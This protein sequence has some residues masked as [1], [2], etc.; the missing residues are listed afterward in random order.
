MKI[1]GAFPVRWAAQDGNDGKSV[2][3]VKTEI[4]YAASTSGTTKPSS[5][6][7]TTIPFVSEGNYLWT[8]THVEYS[9]GTMTDSYST[10]RQGIDGCMMR[11]TEWAKGVEYHNDTSLTTGNRFLDIVCVGVGTSSMERYMCR[12]THTSTDENKPNGSTST[13]WH[14]LDKN[15]PIY[16]PLIMADNAMLRFTQTNQLLL[17]NNSGMVTGGMSGGSSLQIWAGSEGVNED[18]L[19][20]NPKFGVYSDGKSFSEGSMTTYGKNITVDGKNYRLKV[21]EYNGNNDGQMAYYYPIVKMIVCAYIKYPTS[22]T[23]PTLTDDDINTVTVASPLPKTSPNGQTWTDEPIASVGYY[24]AGYKYTIY[25]DTS[26][27]KS[28]VSPINGIQ[29]SPNHTR[30][31]ITQVKMREE[32]FVYDE[33]G[34]ILGLQTKY[35]DKAGNLSWMLDETG[36]FKASLDH[37]WSPNNRRYYFAD[38]SS[39]GIANALSYLNSNAKDPAKFAFPDD[40]AAVFSIFCSANSTDS[41]KKQYDGFCVLGSTVSDVPEGMTG[42]SGVFTSASIPKQMPTQ[43]PIKDGFLIQ[44]IG[45]YFFDFKIYKNGYQ[46]GFVTFTWDGSR[47]VSNRLIR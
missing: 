19:P 36:G 14:K 11:T 27:E 24:W 31:E 1:K 46:Q 39:N 34:N 40:K 41:S 42:F 23:A 33:N 47:W 7:Q 26:I 29:L 32:A 3:I 16:T 21:S 13:Y 4:K 12:V 22:G 2:T 15:F 35:Y 5:G 37:Y 18:N 25:S 45:Q 8:W 6:W 28:A 17:Q 10:V 9:D 44:D 30:T 20:V 43:L 38:G